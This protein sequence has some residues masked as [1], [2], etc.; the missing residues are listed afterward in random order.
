MFF[1]IQK[2]EKDEPQSQLNQITIYFA[3]F[4]FLQ[5]H[6]QQSSNKL[7]YVVFYL[8]NIILENSIVHAGSIS[9]LRT[10]L[11]LLTLYTCRK[12]VINYGTL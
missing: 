5:S 11:S 10:N 7:Y 8:V 12:K 9:L 4:T 6:T 2:S 3:L 1:K